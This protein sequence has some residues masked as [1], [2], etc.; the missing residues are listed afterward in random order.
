MAKIVDNQTGDPTMVFSQDEAMIVR[1]DPD[2]C[3]AYVTLWLSERF[4]E[5]V[6]TKLSK[7]PPL[8]RETIMT[9]LSTYKERAV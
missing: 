7:L 1:H 3:L 6:L 4:R 9:R 8:E 2:A 5:F